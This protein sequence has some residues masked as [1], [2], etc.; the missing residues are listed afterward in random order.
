MGII[1][2]AGESVPAGGFLK[3]VGPS[4][5][6]CTIRADIGTDGRDI[7]TRAE[8][9]APA[10][11]APALTE[12]TVPA[13]PRAVSGDITKRIVCPDITVDTVR[14]GVPSQTATKVT[15][16]APCGVRHLP[17]PSESASRTS[18]RTVLT[19]TSR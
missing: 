2:G 19:L 11:T 6:M 15:N 5:I 12:V 17:F 7:Y 1:G 4:T 16:R 10:W 13:P 8:T 3:G 9:T 18:L 14:R